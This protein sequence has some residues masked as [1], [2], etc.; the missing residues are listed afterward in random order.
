MAIKWIVMDMDGTLLN[1]ENNISEETKRVLMLC[2][3]MGIKLILASG[4]SHRRLDRYAKELKMHEYN[5]FLIEVN[6][7]AK[8]SVTSGERV[9]Y[10]RLNREQMKTLFLS[11]K[12]KG[13][14]IQGYLDDGIYDYIPANVFE[15]KKR[16]RKLRQLAEDYPW[17][18]G[19][20]SLLADTRDGYPN[21]HYIC[22]WAMFPQELNKLS[23]LQEAKEVEKFYPRIMEQFS[24]DYEIV[25][26]CP[27]LIEINPKGISKGSALQRMME[28]AHVGVDEVLVF[29]D[30]ENDTDMFSK[31]KY[32][33]AMGNAA[34]YVKKKAYAITKSNN[35][36]GIAYMVKQYIDIE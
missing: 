34:E 27:G 7:M 25:R 26:T 9:I 29:G 16:E 18:G 4:R 22:D 13:F 12:D 36:D 14:E 15:L 35:E 33:I 21:I 31:V 11:F 1:S 8:K 5:G 24:N 28:E 20:W 6:G 10:K 17:T 19:P 23:L 32:S 2:Q 3:S 30:G